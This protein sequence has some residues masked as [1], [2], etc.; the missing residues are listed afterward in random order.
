MQHI[1][2]QLGGPLVLAMDEVDTIPGSSFRPDFFEMI[3]SWHN[4]RT[5]APSWKQLGL[6]LV[7]STEPYQLVAD[8]NQSP[9]SVGKVIELIDFTL[10]Q[11]KDLNQRHGAPLSPTEARHLMDLLNGHPYLVRRHFMLPRTSK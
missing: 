6:V 1:L 2:Q 10:E 11:V 4:S 9:F 3:R 5:T 7:T 8:L